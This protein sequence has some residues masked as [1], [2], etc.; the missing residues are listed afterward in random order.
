MDITETAYAGQAKEVST[1][2]DLTEFHGIITVSGDGL[3]HEVVNGL[4][5][6]PDWRSAIRTPV[7]VIAA[8]S[9]NGLAKSLNALEPLTAAFNVARGMTRSCDLLSV[10]QAS[11]HR[12]CFLSVS[13]GLISEIDLRSETYRWMGPMRLTVAAVVCISMCTSFFA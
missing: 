9:G 5:E 4:M 10:R 7:G 2:L 8:G 11:A 12:Y 13:W 3:L 6:R 1:Q